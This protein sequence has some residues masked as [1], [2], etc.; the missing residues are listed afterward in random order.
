MQ[1]VFL[2]SVQRE[3]AQER[4][5][6]HRHL[7][8]DPVL[9]LF[10]EPILFEKLPASSSAASAVFLKEVAR[11]DIF[12]IL[13]GEEYG[14]QTPSGISPTELEYDLAQ[15]KRVLSLA[16]IKNDS[17]INRHPKQEIL[18]RKVQ[19]SLAYKRF[20]TTTGLLSEITKALVL[21]LQ[22]KGILRSID[23]DT[24]VNSNATFA[25]IDG[26]KVNHFINLA[27]F[28]RGFPLRQGT[29]LAKVLSHLNFLSSD[30]ITNSALLA[31][32]SNPQQFFPTAVVK[33]AHFHGLLVAK[34]IPDHRVIKGDVFR[35][36]DEVVDFILSKIALSV[37][38][39][40]KD[41]QAPM[42]YEIPRA[43]VAEA[44]VNAIVHRDYISKGSVQ[45]MLFEN[46]L[47]ISNPGG[48]PPELTLDRL[49]THHASYPKNPH[50]AEAMYQAG[51]I[52]R[53]GT[54]T[55]EILRLCEEAHLLEPIF[56]LEEGF[57]VTIWRPNAVKKNF[58]G[59]ATGQ[60]KEGIRRVIYVVDGELNA[61]DI[62]NILDLKHREYFRDTYLLP[63]IEEGYITLT[64]PESP[65][66]PN[67]KYRLTPKGLTLKAFLNTEMHQFNDHATDHVTDEISDHVTD[68]V[69]E[70]LI[71]LS[72]VVDFAYSRQELMDIL[73]LKHS[74]NFRNNYLNP[75]LEG[76]YLEMTIPDKP[77]SVNQ[78]YRLTE[79]GRIFKAELASRNR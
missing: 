28:K 71:K 15:E 64:I 41:N 33:C 5:E 32:G 44:V 34:P 75:L 67:Q 37:G 60:V 23:F 36:V 53:F 22:Q 79:K 7:L 17:E 12:L 50:L 1:K 24:E 10:F 20:T 31:F 72:S 19:N 68:H 25:S 49:R 40:S 63:A 14:F 73:E 11:A 29:A 70:L 48:L 30:K 51:Y 62:M 65:N 38:M 39:R 54:G 27:Q 58:T 8:T 35:Q 3:F 18:F 55:G 43:V 47:E 52:E 61:S 77:R 66:N 78:K 74:Q 57:K 59:Q 16:F 76:A 69:I 46:R 56:D 21:V 9:R 4:D 45:V 42:Q 6:V 26:E 2:S 13:I